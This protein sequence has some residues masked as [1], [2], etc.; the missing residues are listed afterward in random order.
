M[1]Y[2]IYKLWKIILKTELLF[3]NY[4]ITI[5]SKIIVNIKI[6][7]AWEFWKLTSA[8]LKLLRVRNTDV[9]YNIVYY[10]F[11]T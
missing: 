3:T 9:Y 4:T 1:N 7:W 11:Y 5:N 10:K 8:L 6:M 2:S